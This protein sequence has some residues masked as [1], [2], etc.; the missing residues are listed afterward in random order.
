[1]SLPPRARNHPRERSQ[2]LQRP[3]GC[4]YVEPL[5]RMVILRSRYRSFVRLETRKRPQVLRKPF[6]QMCVIGCRCLGTRLSGRLLKNLP[7]G[8]YELSD[9]GRSSPRRLTGEKVCPEHLREGLLIGQIGNHV[10]A[11]I[12]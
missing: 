11:V 4:L 10:S 8:R 3:R 7:H 2:T 6:Y 1:M 9:A 12:T 5:R